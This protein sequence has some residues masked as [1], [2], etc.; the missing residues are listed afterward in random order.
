MSLSVA[1]SMGVQSQRAQFPVATLRNGWSV[2]GS[3]SIGRDIPKVNTT[4]RNVKPITRGGE[5]G[6]AATWCRGFIGLAL[7]EAESRVTVRTMEKS[8]LEVTRSLKACSSVRVRT[9]SF[10]PPGRALIRKNTG[11]DFCRK[12]PFVCGA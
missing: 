8:I 9:A 2:Q 10:R 1:M 3:R 6:R 11:L 4:V 7:K 5:C 12:L